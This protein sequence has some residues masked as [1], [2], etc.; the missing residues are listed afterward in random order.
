MN[1]RTKQ[2]GTCFSASAFFVVKL[3]DRRVKSTIMSEIYGDEIRLA[4]GVQADFFCKADF[5]LA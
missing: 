3:A 1:T 2:K 4:A 5:T